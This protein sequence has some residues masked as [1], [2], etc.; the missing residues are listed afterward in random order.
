M[1]SVAV[2][3]DLKKANDVIAE[4]KSLLKY[5]KELCQQKYQNSDVL[6]K[7]IEETLSMH[8]REW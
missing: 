5:A 1:L 3:V 4:D 8:S 7:A 6:C 2:K